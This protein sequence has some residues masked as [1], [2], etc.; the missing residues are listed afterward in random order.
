MAKLFHFSKGYVIIEVSGSDLERFLNICVRRNI[1]ILDAER[2]SEKAITLCMRAADF[3]RLRPVARKTKS[4]VHIISKPRLYY[5][6]RNR[7]KYIGFCLG[8]VFLV[9]FFAITSQYIWTVEVNGVYHSDYDEIAAILADCGIYPGA[10]KKDMKEKVI[11]KQNLINKTDTISWAWVYIEGGKARIE[12]YE[13]NLP[14]LYMPPGTPCDI[15]AARDGYIEDIVTYAGYDVKKSGTAVEK[16]DVVISGRVPVFKEYDEE[17]RYINVSA[18]GKVRA[19]CTHSVSGIYS[20]V[21]KTATPTGRAKGFLCFEIFGKAFWLFGKDAP[22]FKEYKTTEKRH[23]L[24]IPRWGF[25]GISINT[26]KCE[27]I[28]FEEQTISKEMAEEI[29]KADLEEKIAK[30]LLEDAKLINSEIECQTINET[31]LKVTLTMT[32]SEDIG[33]KQPIKEE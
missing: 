4:K 22:D 6:R 8:L 25:S 17:E 28:V 3:Y 1:R 12:V 11:I 30:E 29:A 27:E 7:H 26:R 5:I 33:I 19:T 15:V 31:D 14:S 23:E 16:G 32:V 13:K 9:L 10:K 20:T 18:H 21:Q 24:T 2:I